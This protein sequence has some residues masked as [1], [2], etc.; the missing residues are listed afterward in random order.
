MRA[1]VYA[2]AFL[3][4]AGAA[5]PEGRPPPKGAPLVLRER[6]NPQGLSRPRGYSQ[7]VATRG[8]KMVFV[9]GQVALDAEGKLVGKGDLK[10]QTEKVYDNL[11]VALAAAGAASQD[12]VKIT[13]FVVNYR[14]GAG[15]VIREV[16]GRFFGETGLPA[17]T[18]VGVQALAREDLLIEVEAIAVV[19]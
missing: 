4:V 12:V 9:A 18:M 13:S 11:R 7:V 1:R 2:T 3:L 16:G 8:G 10:A 15:D 17:S 6:T 5:N 14:P 19:P